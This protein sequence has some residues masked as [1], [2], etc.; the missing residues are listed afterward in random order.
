MYFA[1]DHIYIHKSVDGEPG[2]DKNFEIK[3]LKQR[4]TS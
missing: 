1:Y 2:A 3:K 4:T